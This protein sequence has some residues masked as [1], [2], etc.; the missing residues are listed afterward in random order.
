MSTRDLLFRGRKVVLPEGVRPASIR[1][2]LGRIVEV[3]PED[4]PSHGA[5]AIDAGPHAILPGVVDTHVHLNEPGRTEWEGFAT[6]TRAAAAGGVTTL[7]DMP[8]NSVPATTSLEGLRAKL[9]AAEGKLAVDVGLWGGVIPGN[10]A[11]VA[12]LLDAGVLGF[13]CF[14]VHSGVDEFPAATEVELEAALPIL[15]ARGVPLLAHAE[16]PGPIGAVA[17]KAAQG[18]PR[19]HATWLASRPRASETDAIAMLIAL[20]RKHGAHVHVVHLATADAVP[21]IAAARAE[22]LPLTVETCPH[23][24]A[25]AAEEIADGATAW[26]CAPPIRERDQ[27]EGLWVALRGGAIDLVATDHSPCPPDMKR[28]AEGDFFRAWGGIASLEVG[29]SV[30]HTEARARGLAPDEALHAIAR[31]MSAAPARLAGLSARKGAIE[32]GRDADL[33]LFDPEERWAPDAARLRHRHKV[34]PYA[35]RPLAGRVQRTWLRGALV[36][37][38]DA[39][40]GAPTGRVLLRGA[41]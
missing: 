11:E 34:T 28:M 18:D 39:A 3:G 33:V 15:A 16:L 19:R 23:Y 10:A 29:L 22:G 20:A 26:K 40:P 2:R 7:V 37:D 9:A 17:G 32:V 35:G 31:W 12:P 14:L 4:A 21:M 24:L 30:V 6:G 1:V 5:E 8:L 25:F 36:H 38:G 13:K 41:L 27:R